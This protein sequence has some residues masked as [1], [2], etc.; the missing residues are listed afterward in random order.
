PRLD[1]TLAIV[2][3]IIQ[4]WR[5]ACKR[6]VT[7]YRFLHM[8]PYHLNFR[9]VFHRLRENLRIDG[10]HPLTTLTLQVLFCGKPLRGRSEKTRVD[11][12]RRGDDDLA[13][14]GGD[15]DGQNHGDEE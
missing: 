7:V 12:H 15:G 6:K 11:I 14:L 9:G 8:Q 13:R 5:G 1:E 2:P 4:T 3:T 10:R